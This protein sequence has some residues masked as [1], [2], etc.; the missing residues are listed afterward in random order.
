LPTER[1]P[2]WCQDLKVR[3]GGKGRGQRQRWG[4]GRQRGWG[5]GRRRG[6]RKGGEES[7]PVARVGERAAGTVGAAARVRNGGLGEDALGQPTGLIIYWT[8]RPAGR[9]AGNQPTKRLV[10]SRWSSPAGCGPTEQ[11]DYHSRHRFAEI[12][13]YS[14]KGMPYYINCSHDCNPPPL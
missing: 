1:L 2:P 5:S 4:S 9:T 3:R 12:G 10:A 8:S 6:W 7:R 11:A 14:A 13:T